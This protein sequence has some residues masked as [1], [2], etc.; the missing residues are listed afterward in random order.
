MSL[1]ALP[2]VFLAILA[3]SLS[4]RW[5]PF[6]VGVISLVFVITGTLVFIAGESFLFA[7]VGRIVAGVGAAAIAIV[8]AQI[9]SQW[10]REREL[11]AAMGIFNT[12][13][14][15]GTIVCF[16][17]FGR[18]GESLGWRMPMFV[19]LMI[20]VLGLIV[21]VIF[22]RGSPQ[23]AHTTAYGKQ[24]KATLFSS[25][26]KVGILLWLAGLCWMWFN[27]SIISFSTFAPDFFISKG[28]TIGFAGLLTSLLMWGSLGLSPVI[29]RSLDK[30]GNNDVF[31]AVGGVMIAIAI[32]LITRGVNFLFAMVIMA[33]AVSF[34]PAPLYALLPKISKSENLGLAFGI[35]SMFASMGMLFGP[36][37]TGLIRQGTGSYQLGFV[38]LS[39]LA[40]L[41]TS[42]ALLSRSRMLRA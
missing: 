3:G 12:A 40:L 11:G 7:G 2:S 17:T 26:A 23:Q 20:G 24:E 9:I 38:F 32:L 14:P 8:S 5:G 33:V 10:F 16:T 1:F 21:F 18:L 19:T 25:L 34:I 6:R 27:A 29:G 30:I 22:Y 28:Y 13:M 39:I 36:Y 31:I 42:T 37:A 15:V 4:D 35:L 41:V